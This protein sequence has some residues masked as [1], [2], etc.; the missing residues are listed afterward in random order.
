[1]IHTAGND[2]YGGNILGY[3]PPVSQIRQNSTAMK[4]TPKRP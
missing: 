1:M 4:Q 3:A 2:F